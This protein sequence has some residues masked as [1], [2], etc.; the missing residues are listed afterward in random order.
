MFGYN[1]GSDA[2]MDFLEKGIIDKLL[3]AASIMG[4][5]VMGGLIVNYVKV[6][7]GTC[8]SYIR[9]RFLTSGEPV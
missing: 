9:I 6:K 5:M 1:A 7:C 4:C 2:I 8:N 3:K